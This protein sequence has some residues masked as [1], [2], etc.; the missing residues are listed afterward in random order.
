MSRSPDAARPHRITPASPA[1]VAQLESIEPRLLCSVAF[2]D[3]TGYIEVAATRRADVVYANLRKGRLKIT[4]NGVVEAGFRLRGVAG[5][6]VQTG[7]GNDTVTLAASVP[8]PC[9]ITG[10]SGNDTLAGADYA[11]TL[12]GGG[13]DDSLV[14]GAGDD[15][16][17]G[18]A[19][20]DTLY[21]GAGADHLSG[22]DGRDGLFG[23]IGEPDTLDGGA[24][25]DRFLLPESADHAVR[26]EDTASFSTANQDARVW[27][28]PGAAAWTDDDVQAI[29]AGLAVLHLRMN[30][31]QLLRL[32]PAADPAFH[33]REQIFVRM[34]PSDAFAA[35]NG[36]EF[37]INVYDGAFGSGPFTASTVFHEVGHNWDTAQENAFWSAGH[38]FLALSNWLPYQ[39]TDPI[40]AGQTLSADGQWTYAAHATF[41]TNYART[42]PLEDFAESVATYFQYPRSDINSPVKW[43][44]V[45]AFVHDLNTQA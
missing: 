36:R 2:N 29:D 42:N 4:V 35:T 14:G 16:L 30:G 39:P 38:D 20:N 28:E 19:G 7:K 9:S 44:Y 23:G 34:G 8:L 43:D 41:P 31:T 32:S 26:D 17:A 37:G 13:G 12:V 11:D 27:F 45:D 18:F 40:P 5:L 1:R 22:G 25:D 24:G 3:S 15:S 6:Q 33:D 10:D 21:G